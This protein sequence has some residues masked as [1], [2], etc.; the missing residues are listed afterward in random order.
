[1][2]VELKIKSKH[3]GEEAK[4]IRFEEHKL[5]RQIVWLESHQK[6]AR[7]LR[8]TWLSIKDHR[9]RDVRQENRATFLARAFI[10]G[11]PYKSVEAKVHDS[12]TLYGMLN[13]RVFEMVAK[14]GNNKIFKKWNSTSRKSEFDPAEAAAL[15]KKL[16]AWA[17]I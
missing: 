14:Y 1:M 2:S 9:R 4:I 11:K 10:A 12:G 5:K 6:D 16:L 17:E 7:K 13:N 8:D 3:L 15:R